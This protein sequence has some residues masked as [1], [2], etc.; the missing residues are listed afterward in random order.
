MKGSDVKFQLTVIKTITEKNVQC[1]KKTWNKNQRS[2]DGCGSVDW[3]IPSQGTSLGCGPGPWLEVCEKQLTFLLHIDVSLSFSL[4]LFSL[5]INKIFREK[6]RI[7]GNSAL[8][9]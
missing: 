4:P 9:N 2:P 8:A 6:K 1:E 5:K 3:A 7:K